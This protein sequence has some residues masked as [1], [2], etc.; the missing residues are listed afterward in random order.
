M[1]LNVSVL[2][3]HLVHS[4]HLEVTLILSLRFPSQMKA[5]FAFTPFPFETYFSMFFFHFLCNNQAPFA[6]AQFFYQV[7]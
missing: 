6:Q 2:L 4:L 3:I 7:T 1:P 5:R